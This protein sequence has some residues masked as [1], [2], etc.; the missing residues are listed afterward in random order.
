[1]QGS[2]NLGLVALAWLWVGVD[3]AL[4]VDLAVQGQATSPG[5]KHPA[6]VRGVTFS[7]RRPLA[8]PA[9]HVEP[10]PHTLLFNMQAM[11]RLH[12]AQ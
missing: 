6:A 4:A 3:L 11:S 5:S 2:V 9:S 8:L 1:M 12:C 7:S 10:G